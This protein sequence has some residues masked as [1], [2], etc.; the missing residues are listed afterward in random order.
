MKQDITNLDD[1]KL[2]V[3]TFYGKVRANEVLGH[4]FEKR[5]QDNW[6]THLDKMYRFWQTILLEARTYSGTPFA[7]HATMPINAEHFENW[8]VLFHQT[9]DDLF[10]GKVADEAKWRANKMAELFQIKLQH[11]RDNGIKPLV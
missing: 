7:P 3:D 8:L 9:V 10:E 1:I 4:I 6:P 2:L 11:F 5:I